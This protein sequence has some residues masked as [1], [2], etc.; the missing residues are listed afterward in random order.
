MDRPRVSSSVVFRQL[1]LPGSVRM[2]ILEMDMAHVDI[3]PGKCGSKKDHAR[4]ERK[5]ILGVYT[6]WVDS[7]VTSTDYLLG[8]YLNPSSHV[9]KQNLAWAHIGNR[10]IM[11]SS[12]LRTQQFPTGDRQFE[13]S[14]QKDSL[15]RTC[16]CPTAIIMSNH[17]TTDVNGGR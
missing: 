5:G 10:D 13:N 15:R 4:H 6:T 12:I 17:L 11:T 8:I 2:R 1:H 3:F 9:N 14:K 7:R 16:Q